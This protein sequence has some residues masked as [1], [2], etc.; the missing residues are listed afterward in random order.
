MRLKANVDEFMIED[1]DGVD[2]VPVGSTPQA[3]SQTP[4]LGRKQSAVCWLP[5][6]LQNMAVA[7]AGSWD[8]PMNEVALWGWG[9]SPSDFVDADM[10][11]EEASEPVKLCSAPHEG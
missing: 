7:A 5:S 2:E 11:N 1:D 8:E 10:A 9:G 3:V 4:S 6:R